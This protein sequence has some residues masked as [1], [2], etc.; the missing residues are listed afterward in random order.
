MRCLFLFFFFS[1]QNYLSN[2]GYSIEHRDVTCL[3]KTSTNS[4]RTVDL[5]H[6]YLPDLNWIFTSHKFME[7]I[8]QYNFRILTLYTT[9]SFISQM[10]RRWQPCSCSVI[11][12]CSYES[13]Q[14]SV[15][16]HVKLIKSTKHLYDTFFN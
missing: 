6:H 4:F 10:V 14:N 1:D 5:R 2:I 3:P 11:K 8:K 15:L 13:T 9:S 16:F 7:F 12:P